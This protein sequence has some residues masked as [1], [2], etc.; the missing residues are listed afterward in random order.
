MRNARKILLSF[1][2]IFAIVLFVG[3][4]Y[5]IP[6]RDKIT[7]F[8]SIYNNL[9]NTSNN[10]T[11]KPSSILDDEKLEGLTVSQRKRLIVEEYTRISFTVIIYK[12]TENNS[13]TTVETEKS[14][15]SGFIIHS[16]GYILTNHHVINKVANPEE[17]ENYKVYVSQDGGENSYE[18]ELLWSN[19]VFDLAILVCEEFKDLEP[20][21]L[22]DRNIYCDESERIKSPDEVI[23]IGTTIAKE[24]YASSTVGTISS[25]DWRVARADGDFYEHLIQHTAPINHGNSGGPLID[26]YGNVIGVNALGNDGANSF[27]FAVPIY[28]AIKI[29]DEVVNNYENYKEGTEEILFGFEGTDK[30]LLSQSANPSISFNRDGA[31]VV[32]ILEGCIIN[33]LQKKDVIIGAEMVIKGKTEYFEIKD[34]NMLLYSRISLLYADSAKIKVLRNGVEFLLNVDLGV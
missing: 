17:A 15:G 20:A 30:Y 2:M 18:A 25:A 33:G 21:K 26:L 34:Q 6:Y 11:V 27:F 1:V 10:S 14:F 29:L 4:S 28:P 19:Q 5:A 23:A 16:G 12:I 3:C 7:N 32:S 9:G 31:Y 8:S 13:N 24:Y 22:K